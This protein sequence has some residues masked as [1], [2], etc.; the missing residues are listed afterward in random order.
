MIDTLSFDDKVVDEITKQHPEVPISAIL[1]FIVFYELKKHYAIEDWDLTDAACADYQKII[2]L[3]NGL[4]ST[5]PLV[6]QN[7]RFSRIILD[8][9][10]LFFALVKAAEGLLKSTITVT[11][12]MDT[13]KR[14]PGNTPSGNR[15]KEESIQG[16]LLHAKALITMAYDLVSTKET[17]SRNHFEQLVKVESEEDKELLKGDRMTSFYQLPNHLFLINMQ[18][19]KSVYANT[20]QMIAIFNSP[21]TQTPVAPAQPV[22]KERETV[23]EKGAAAVVIQPEV[24]EIQEVIEEIGDKDQSPAPAKE[25]PPL[26]SLDKEVDFGRLAGSDFKE[27][28]VFHMDIEGHQKQL[29]AEENFTYKHNDADLDSKLDVTGINLLFGGKGVLARTRIKAKEI[30]CVYEG[31]KITEDDANSIPKEEL[32]THYFMRL[33]QSKT[34]IDARLSGNV[35]RFFN[36][37]KHTPNAEFRKR[38]IRTEDGKVSFEIVVMAIRDIEPGEQILVNY[39]D[40]YDYGDIQRVFLHHSD[41]P[42]NSKQLLHKYQQ[43][44][45]KTAVLFHNKGE[46]QETNTPGE[47]NGLYLDVVERAILP[48]AL[49]DILAEKKEVRA[50]EHPDLPVLFITPENELQENSTTERL[51]S[52]MIASYLG[53]AEGVEAL[54]KMKADPAMQSRRAGLSSFHMVM[55]G[56]YFGVS[57]GDAKS[58]RKI[59]EL[60]RKEKVNLMLEDDD[61]L[62]V[63]DWALRL[64]TTDC[65][66]ELIKD[67]RPSALSKL[68]E[69]KSSASEKFSSLIAE[70]KW[71]HC[72]VILNKIAQKSFVYSAEINKLLKELTQHDK[73]KSSKETSPATTQ[74]KEEGNVPPRE[75][76]RQRTPGRHNTDPTFFSGQ[77]K[78]RKQ[79]AKKESN[80][81]EPLQTESP[82][83]IQANE[84]A[85]PVRTR[86][87]IHKEIPPDYSPGRK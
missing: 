53:L 72:Q 10:S 50:L 14:L 70:E 5:I 82:A 66:E 64:K 34:I 46:N 86:Q 87:K 75:A 4:K 21:R 19:W 15:I 9:V 1:E 47:L 51:S 69:H 8:K 60:F 49:A 63:F 39:S 36:E 55:A 17:L 42:Y 20:P 65:L 22:T 68:L 33:G 16:K 26:V 85:A 23:E 30:F 11:A 29:A 67:M 48:I 56:E 38:P 81:Q 79:A 31:A 74:T 35:A 43:E 2:S 76:K 41:G 37:S 27:P 57:S 71:A 58:R 45:S 32:N 78:K 6:V 13:V 73:L 84:R 44:Y 28:A 3:Y 12:S 77:N 54:L 18:L 7:D 59:I 24:Q 61:G 40:D 62:T 25:S 83:S 80:L 52:L